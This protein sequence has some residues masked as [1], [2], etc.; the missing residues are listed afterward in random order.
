M[1]LN[2]HDGGDGKP[3]HGNDNKEEELSHEE[4]FDDILTSLKQNTLDIHRTSQVIILACNVRAKL[5]F[6]LF[7]LFV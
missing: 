2:N 4:Y 7:D 5:F 6:N 3:D 1:S